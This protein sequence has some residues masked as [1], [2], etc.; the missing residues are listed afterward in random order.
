MDSAMPSIRDKCGIP[1]DVGACPVP[2]GINLDDVQVCLDLPDLV[3]MAASAGSQRDFWYSRQLEP[4]QTLEIAVSYH[5]HPVKMVEPVSTSVTLHPV[6]PPRGTLR[7]ARNGERAPTDVELAR[8]C[9]HFNVENV[10]VSSA[11][12]KAYSQTKNTEKP[13]WELM[14]QIL[15]PTGERGEL[16][17]QDA[18][19]Q[20]LGDTWD[21]L[22]NFDPRLSDPETVERVLRVVEKPV[23]RPRPVKRHLLKPPGFLFYARSGDEEIEV[24]AG[25]SQ[26]GILTIEAVAFI[27]DGGPPFTLRDRRGVPV[28]FGGVN[29]RK[30]IA[31][32]PELALYVTT[33][34]SVLSSPTVITREMR[35]GRRR[36]ALRIPS[37]V[38]PN[39]AGLVPVD[40][41][42]SLWIEYSVKANGRAIANF[43]SGY[44][45][46]LTVKTP[47]GVL[48]WDLQK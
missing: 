41:W 5:D 25:G 22:R 42:F 9:H 45:L 26:E 36:F 38:Q 18:R 21:R 7:W 29:W 6:T 35:L 27:P 20:A 33:L 3:S 31:K 12:N 10:R 14:T 2:V 47:D 19:V 46:D 39:V 48:T 32:H 30:H 16:R 44:V 40:G 17:V 8:L 28:V 11:E 4:H 24:V 43:L 37:S 1:V 23:E 13:R 34:Q 15:S